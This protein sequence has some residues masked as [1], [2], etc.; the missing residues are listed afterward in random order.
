MSELG[1]IRESTFDRLDY[2]VDCDCLGND[3]PL[4]DNLISRPERQRFMILTY[5]HLRD[6]FLEQIAKSKEGSRNNNEQEMMAR[7]HILD[8]N[9]EA[10]AKL[11]ALA[12]RE[13]D[14]CRSEFVDHP[15]SL[16]HLHKIKGKYLK[17]FVQARR[18]THSKEKVVGKI[19]KPSDVQEILCKLDSD[20]SYPI[21]SKEDSVLLRA[22]MNRSVV[23]L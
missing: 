15:P 18:C 23:D 14:S 22:F 11:H 2:P 19:G 1:H 4:P 3:H 12:G 10:E 7:Q 13:R 9:A 21:A 5:K 17:P 8:A 6:Q 20:P 16:Q